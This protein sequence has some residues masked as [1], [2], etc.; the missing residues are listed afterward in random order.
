MFTWDEVIDVALGIE[1][2]GEETYRQTAKKIKGP[3]MSEALTWLADDEARHHKWFTR[4]RPQQPTAAPSSKLEKISRTLMRDMVENQAQF[5]QPDQLI[6]ATDLTEL[7]VTA[8]EAE[9]ETARFYELIAL[10]L[11]NSGTYKKIE[12]IIA[13]EYRHAE[14]LE[15]WLSEG[16]LP[17]TPSA[18]KSPAA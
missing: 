11:E 14:V 18:F 3:K 5:H 13:E 16:K 7:L 12:V 9:K 1:Q 10:M 4:L 6:H 8:M 15:K 2:A 17:E